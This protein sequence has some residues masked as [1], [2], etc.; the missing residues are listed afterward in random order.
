MSEQHSNS[1]VGIDFVRRCDIDPTR[2]AYWWSPELLLRLSGAVAGALVEK[3][4]I[5]FDKLEPLRMFI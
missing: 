2:I 1:R 3:G 4:K 5:T